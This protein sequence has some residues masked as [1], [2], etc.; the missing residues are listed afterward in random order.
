[1]REHTT[2]ERNTHADWLSQIGIGTWTWDPGQNVVHWDRGAEAVYGMEP[3]SFAG[4]FESFL[5]KIHPEDLEDVTALIGQ[6]AEK[7]GDYSIRHRIVWPDGSV[8][9]IEGQG[10]IT[11]D[12]DG[13]PIDGRGIVY[14]L[15][16][17]VTLDRERMVLIANEELARSES[18]ADRERLQFLMDLTEAIA[19]SLN[20]ERVAS[21][22]ARL[23]S[24][25]LAAACIVDVKLQDPYGHLLS[26]AA[27]AGGT[28]VMLSG[29]SHDLPAAAARLTI[30]VGE[31][32]AAD[33]PALTV[34][35]HADLRESMPQAPD[36]STLAFPL[37]AHG[38]RIG[39]V[40]LVRDG[41]PWSERARM[42]LA[43]ASRRAASAI[44]RA[45]IHADRSKFVSMFQAAATPRD[46]PE[47]PG[48]EI[49]AHYRPATDL[50]RLGGDFYDIVE[51][52]DGR[53]LVFVGDVS[54][55]GIVAA[56][57]AEL[58]RTALRAAGMAT[59]DAV[60]SL[61]VLNSSLLAEPTKPMLTAAVMII[62]TDGSGSRAQVA[63]AGHPPPLVIE[64]HDRWRT[65]EVRGTMA[66]VMPDP[67]FEDADVTL[68]PGQSLVLYT[69]GITESR[70]GDEF[71]GVERLGK[72]AS[73]AWPASA[74]SMIAGIGSSIETWAAGQPDDDLLVLVARADD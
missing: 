21:Q 19:G 72:I 1:M 14:L 27:V 48:M 15:S 22:F 52:A 10:R 20:T 69:D 41:Q 4:D 73:A 30:A 56:A 13:T 12:E 35:D 47:V 8:R 39:T 49:A 31:D 71:F 59:H 45:E 32:G 64:G 34:V 44:D 57:H 25:R 54:G 60:D 28:P 55:K 17:R 33:H 50:V 53:W 58:A 38:T 51:L 42:L 37:I 36:A 43:A 70:F 9:W 23:V 11:V 74:R 24:E 40:V 65:L 7:G 26:C 63:V 29:T 68:E 61:R 18:S 46:L 16:D 6:V 62:Q 2:S 5:A 66:G 3:G 67:H